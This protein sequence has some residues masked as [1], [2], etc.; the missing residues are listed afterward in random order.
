MSRFFWQYQHRTPN[1]DYYKKIKNTLTP[2]R[3]HAASTE[4]IPHSTNNFQN[5]LP[6]FR[7]TSL[8]LF[9]ASTVYLHG[10]SNSNMLRNNLQIRL[11]PLKSPILFKYTHENK[12]GNTCSPWGK[13]EKIH[14]PFFLTILKFLSHI[15]HTLA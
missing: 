11:S 4:R 2:L 5:L 14:F 12:L 10:A 8:N 6:T 7:V 9:S 13:F 3:L 1:Y 15:F